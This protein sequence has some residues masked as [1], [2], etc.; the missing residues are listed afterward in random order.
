MLIISG[1]QPTYLPW[2][3]LFHKFSLC[4]KFVFMDTVQYLDGDWNNR[5]KI[6]T[7]Q[8]PLYL[9]V[10]IDK[11]KSNFNNL[12]EIYI[13]GYLNKDSRDFWQKK[14]WKSILIN[15]SKAP[16]FKEFSDELE[17]TYVNKV[18]KKLS[19][20]CWHQLNFF[21][22]ILKLNNIEIIKM[23]EFRFEGRKDDL[24][25]NHCKKLKGNAVVFGKHGKDYVNLEKF[26]KEKILVYFQNFKHPTYKQNY[27]GF[28]ENLSILDLLLNHGSEKSIE[29][30]KKDN[31]TIDQL[32][33]SNDWENYKQINQ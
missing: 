29:I 3:G 20:L 5:N 8:S 11:K 26:N 18:W 32:K 28:E 9:T 24:V 27:R 22:K 7:S 13:H 31:I 1:H 4:D 30:I 14:H 2:L 23:S 15:Y 19:D 10:P 33:K 16:Y 21:L 12:N 6:K 17:N 25:L